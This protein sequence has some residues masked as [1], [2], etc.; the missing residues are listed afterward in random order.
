MSKMY[1][2]VRAIPYEGDR[3][4]GVYATKDDAEAAAK[5]WWNEDKFNATDDLWIYECVVGAAPSMDPAAEWR[6]QS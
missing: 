1:L 4:L 2:L 3:Y 6:V 5:V